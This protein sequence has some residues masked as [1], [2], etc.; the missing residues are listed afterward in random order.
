MFIF[1]TF[2]THNLPGGRLKKTLSWRCKSFPHSS[3]NHFLLSFCSLS[4]R[5]QKTLVQPFHPSSIVNVHHGKKQM[6]N[7]VLQ[8]LQKVESSLDLSMVTKCDLGVYSHCLQ[9]LYGGSGRVITV[10]FAR[11]LQKCH[12][13][14]HSIDEAMLGQAGKPSNHHTNQDCNERRTVL[15]GGHIL[16]QKQPESGLQLGHS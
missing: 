6:P 9:L 5:N 14:H 8:L 7:N 13:M 2:A 12:Q 11:I 10:S 3:S 1:V 16:L 15:P 4:P